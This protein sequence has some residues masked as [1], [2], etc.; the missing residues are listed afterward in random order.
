[1]QQGWRQNQMRQNGYGNYYQGSPEKQPLQPLRAASTAST[2]AKLKLDIVGSREVK[3][4]P[5]FFCRLQS[6][7]SG[8]S[9]LPLLLLTS[10]GISLLPLLLRCSFCC[11]CIR[12][13]CLCCTLSPSC[14]HMSLSC[15][16]M[17]GVMTNTCRRWPLKAPTARRL[18]CCRSQT[19]SSCWAC[20]L[21]RQCKNHSQ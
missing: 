14:C 9:L 11:S 17:S 20:R 21:W 6:T 18:T 7:T 8:I 2:T 3:Q 10:S 13:T 12:C 4:K 5:S 1:M 19:G 16:S 15:S